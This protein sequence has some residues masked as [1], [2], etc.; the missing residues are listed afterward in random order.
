MKVNAATVWT[1]VPAAT[2]MAAAMVVFVF[3][4]LGWM[5]ANFQTVSAS[6]AYQKQVYSKIDGS[7]VENIEAQIAGYRY[8]LLSTSLTQEQKDWINA[9]IARLNELIAC[10]R[11]RNC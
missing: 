11:A 3:S 8:Q 4:A 7:R 6:E 9:E 10:I 1:T 2:K 5:S